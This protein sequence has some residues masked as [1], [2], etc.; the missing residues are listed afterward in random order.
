MNP[1]VQKFILLTL[2]PATAG[3]GLLCLIISESA[4]SATTGIIAIDAGTSV[5]ILTLFSRMLNLNLKYYRPSGRK[6]WII[7]AWILV[8][9][10]I[11]WFSTSLIITSVPLT[12]V[13]YRDLLYDTFVL[14]LSL[15]LLIL[16]CVALVSWIRGQSAETEKINARLAEVRELNRQAELHNLRQQLKPHFLFNSLNSIHALILHNPEKS[17]QMLLNLSEFLRGT[18]RKENL[19]MQTVEQEMR[20]TNLYLEIE[21]VRFG[22]RMKVTT[23]IDEACLNFRVPALI[24][25]P[26]VE[27]AIKHGIYNTEGDVNINIQC[28]KTEEGCSFSISNPFEINPADKSDRTGAGFGLSSIKR[29]LFLLY[30]K[31]H[32]LTTFQHERIFT[33]NINIP[34]T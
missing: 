29:R 11:W 5:L 14:R 24:L 28:R 21:Q 13:A 4:P 1:A 18:P 12:P 27:N 17:R 10:L 33:T 30:G 32:L 23:E 3:F 22:D 7:A 2:L 16:G 25:Q 8:Y 9:S 26:V 31:Q 19:S 15:A 34:A 20:Q 6:S